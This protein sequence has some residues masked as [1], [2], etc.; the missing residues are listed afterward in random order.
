MYSA[1]QVVAAIFAVVVGG[2][3]VEKLK[4]ESY[5]CYCCFQQAVLDL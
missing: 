1:E 4:I 5:Y 2:D 3:D